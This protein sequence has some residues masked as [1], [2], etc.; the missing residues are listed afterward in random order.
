MKQIIA[1]FEISK[2]KMI[3]FCF[4]DIENKI[5][6]FYE[7][8]TN[9]HQFDEI[10][11]T[12]YDKNKNNEVIIYKGALDEA[13]MVFAGDLEDAMQKNRELPGFV[14]VGSL[15]Y[16]LNESYQ[17]KIEKNYKKIKLEKF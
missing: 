14:P 9:L 13:F 15:N 2:N 6:Y 5:N 17:K 4:P 16:F 8:T 11:G 1:Q 10:I 12:F 7:P 3:E